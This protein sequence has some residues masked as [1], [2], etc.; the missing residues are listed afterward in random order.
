[1][2]GIV[3]QVVHVEGMHC[4]HCAA[5]VEEALS[6]VAGVRSAKVNL[7]KKIATIKAKPAVAEADIKKAIDET[8]F[9]FAGLE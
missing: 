1:M 3:T 2:F 7:N 4:A 9:T 5:R 6:G 8:G